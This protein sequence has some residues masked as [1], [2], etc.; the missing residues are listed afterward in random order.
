VI[1]EASSGTPKVVLIAS[2]SELSVALDARDALEAAGTPT[3]VVSLPSW[4]L[5]ARQDQ[6]Y[7]DEVLPPHVSAR[8]SIEAGATFGWERWIGCSGFAVGLDHFGASAP[9]E[10]LYQEF[11][12]G[13]G[14]VVAAATALL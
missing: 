11:G 3:R 2:G 14:D 9:A 7:R 5:F 1:A 8:V 13:A 12:L 4:Y 6:A 10:R